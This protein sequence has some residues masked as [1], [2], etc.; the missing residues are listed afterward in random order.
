MAQAYQGIASK[1][2]TWVES[3][4]RVLW[5]TGDTFYDLERTSS[6]Y[7]LSR[8]MGTYSLSSFS[9]SENIPFNIIVN[10]VGTAQHV[11]YGFSDNHHSATLTASGG[12]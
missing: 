4:Q 5:Q 9:A 10:R 12:T 1:F 7:S 6:L 11:N 8:T 2:P 3:N